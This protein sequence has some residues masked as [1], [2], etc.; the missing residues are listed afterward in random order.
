[1]KTVI[2][3]LVAMLATGPVYA[4]YGEDPDDPAAVDAARAAFARLNHGGAGVDL[5]FA[6]G[7]ALAADVVEIIGVQSALTA[8][9]TPLEEAI[10]ALDARVSDTLV[11]V[12]LS[13]DVLFDFDS[14]QLKPE[15]DESLE[16][17]GTLIN[18]SEVLSVTIVGHTDAKGSEEYNLDLS[19]RRAASV[20]DWL[21][22]AGIDPGLFT[23]EGRG[24]ADP[25]APNEN[26]DGSDNPD[27]RA[28][29]RRVEIV[30][31]TRQPIS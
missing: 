17:L 15:A 26:E 18:E 9:V 22:A 10:E 11:E 25:V 21:V 3:I 13:S 7:S 27:G 8:D 6:P 28:L 19:N 20:R 24:E 23:V 1:M 2:S 31:R 12:S 30:I 16:K 14:D 5:V 29:N 4:S